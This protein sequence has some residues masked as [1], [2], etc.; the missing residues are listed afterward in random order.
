[1]NLEDFKEIVNSIIFLAMFLVAFISI[2][3]Q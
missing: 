2:L 1:M 3:Y